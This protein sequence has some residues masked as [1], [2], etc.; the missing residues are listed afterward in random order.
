[1]WSRRKA[2]KQCNGLRPAAIRARGR[3]GIAGMRYAC[4]RMENTGG[5]PNRRSPRRSALRAVAR[6][7]RRYAAGRRALDAS[8]TLRAMLWAA[9]AGFVLTVLNTLLRAVSLSL[10]PLQA[11]FLRYLF[12]LLV[13]MPF[14]LRQGLAGYRPNGLAGQFWRGATHTVALTLWFIALPHVP[15][16]DVTAIGF[17]GPIFTLIGAVLIFGEKLSPARIVATV[18]GF[19]GVLVV[20]GPRLAGTGGGWSLVMLASA[21]LFSASF[22]ITKALTRRDRAEVIVVWQAITVS[23]FSL[24]AALLNWTWPSPGQ[25]LLFAVGGVLGSIGHYCLTRS[26]GTADISATQSIK[27]LDLLWASLLGLLVFGD[28]PTRD[29]LVGGAIILLATLW[30]ARREASAARAVR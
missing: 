13:M 21:P 19:L 16:A 11:Q 18:V 9:T 7:R 29:A 26:F 10:D 6:V 17:T 24:P 14:V 1:M 28:W 27:F 3:T 22:L 20:I 2:A 25:W 4:A 12:G 5:A 15:L 30:L 23:L 8:A